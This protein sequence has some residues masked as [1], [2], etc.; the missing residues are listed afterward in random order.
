[1]IHIDREQHARAQFNFRRNVNWKRHQAISLRSAYGTA[2]V[3]EIDDHCW[4]KLAEH[5]PTSVTCHVLLI[6]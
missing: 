6:T 4:F 3:V 1:M 2:A 5:H